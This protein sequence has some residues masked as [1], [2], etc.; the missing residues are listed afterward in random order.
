QRRQWVRVR[1][2][3]PVEL[4]GTGTRK[5]SLSTSTVDISGGGVRLGDARPMRRGDGVS[6]AIEL[7]DGSV[8]VTGRILDIASG[9]EA[10]VKFEGL[11]EGA[12]KRIVR[13]V[14]DVQRDSGRTAG[15]GVGPESK[16]AR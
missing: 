2:A 1:V 15:S 12:S 10:R 9:G 16:T 6:M 5:A 8:E 14:F 13:F 3:V 7:P 11:S 4:K